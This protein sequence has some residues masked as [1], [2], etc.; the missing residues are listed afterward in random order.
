M[1]RIMV[2][3][4]AALALAACGKQAPEVSVNDQVPADQRTES[5]AAASEGQADGDTG[6]GWGGGAGEATWV[7]VDIDFESAPTEV[8]SGSEITL[9]N[10]GSTLHNVTINDKVIVEAEGG[11]TKSATLD[12]EPGSY[13]FVC[14][15][16][17][18]DSLMKGKVEV[19]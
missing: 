16:P 15:V 18:H 5:A 19:K 7:A 10:Q 17:G 11:A 12:L 4:V 14:S 3:L 8:K 13:D 2:V 1:R 6:D 9:D